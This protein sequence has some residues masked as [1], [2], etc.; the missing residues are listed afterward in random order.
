MK[1]KI[2][3]RA[4]GHDGKGPISKFLSFVDT[5]ISLLSAKKQDEM[6]MQNKPITQNELLLCL[7]I[8]F[9]LFWPDVISTTDENC[10]F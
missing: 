3:S 8:D 5:F 10:R 2:S 6:Q 7:P 1:I 4:K 9:L